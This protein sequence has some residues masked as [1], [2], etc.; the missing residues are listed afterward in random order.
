MIAFCAKHTSH[1][2][3]VFLY[4]IYKAQRYSGES[5]FNGSHRDIIN[6]QRAENFFFYFGDIIPLVKVWDL[7]VQT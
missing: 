5:I 6:F 1:Y 2:M 4:I 3:Y 7:V